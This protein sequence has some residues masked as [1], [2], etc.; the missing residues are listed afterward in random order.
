MRFPADCPNRTENGGGSLKDLKGF[1][2]VVNRTFE[3]KEFP[4]Y[5]LICNGSLLICVPGYQGF[6]ASIPFGGHKEPN[7]TVGAKAE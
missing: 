7:S 4:A 3:Y 2:R 5:S 6:K 1:S